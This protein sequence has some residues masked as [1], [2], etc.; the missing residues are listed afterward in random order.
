MNVKNFCIAKFSID[1]DFK[2]NLWINFKHFLLHT[3]LNLKAKKKVVR[4]GKEV[5]GWNTPESG[6]KL[7]FN[8]RPLIF[9]YYRSG[10][11]LLTSVNVT[12]RD[13]R[14]GVPGDWWSR[15]VVVRDW[16][17][18]GTA[19]LVSFASFEIKAMLILFFNSEEHPSIRVCFP[20]ASKRHQL[21]ITRPLA[22]NVL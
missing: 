5:D 16:G 8:R 21:V 10:D 11:W 22:S 1:L 12:S 7:I 20:G 6:V 15:K 3:N 4:Q 18:V 17:S 9:L 2:F 14:C 13:E 19:K